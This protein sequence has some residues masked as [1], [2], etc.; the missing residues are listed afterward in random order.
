VTHYRYVCDCLRHLLTRCG[1]RHFSAAVAAIRYAGVPLAR[2][3]NAA[4]I[5]LPSGCVR[6]N[7]RCWARYDIIIFPRR[8]TRARL[9]VGGALACRHIVVRGWACRRAHYRIIGRAACI[10][11]ACCGVPI[12]CV[13]ANILVTCLPVAVGMRRAEQTFVPYVTRRYKTGAMTPRRI[14]VPLLATRTL[15]HSARRARRVRRRKF[16][17]L[18]SPRATSPRIDWRH[19]FTDCFATLPYVVAV[20]I[21]PPCCWRRPSCAVSANLTFC[22]VTACRTCTEEGADAAV[23]DC[24]RGDGDLFSA[25]LRAVPCLPFLI[26]CACLR[27]IFRAGVQ[28][29]DL[30]V[31]QSAVR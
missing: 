25:C 30:P 29:T 11:Y 9:R 15:S 13:G 8:G 3:R 14:S 18:T 10:W 4:A 2:I 7:L 1:E 23:R 5:S 22:G 6:R 31:L 19:L 12:R 26:I 27:R 21:F 16:L 28:I 20:S 24:C 17:R